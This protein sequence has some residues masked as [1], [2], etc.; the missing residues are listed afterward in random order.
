MPELPSVSQSFNIQRVRGS[1]LGASGRPSSLA[2]PA[3]ACRQAGFGSVSQT[4]D[5]CRRDGR[6]MFHATASLFGLF[7]VQRKPLGKGQ[8]IRIFSGNEKSGS[9]SSP[10]AIAHAR[11]GKFTPACIAKAELPQSRPFTSMKYAFPSSSLTMNSTSAGPFHFK[12]S[13]YRTASSK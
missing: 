7:A 4:S 11:A 12:S 6:K 5:P 3:L 10:T 1:K 13:S 2:K 9:T 8:R